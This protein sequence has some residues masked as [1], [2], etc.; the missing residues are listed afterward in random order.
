MI[1][2]KE[3]DRIRLVHMPDDPDPIPDGA[4]GTVRRVH[5]PF[6]EGRMHVSVEWDEG[7]G[8]SLALVVPP[9]VV[10]VI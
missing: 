10:E 3:G 5:D 2:L 6:H 9:D 8:R 1:E 7:V 4:T